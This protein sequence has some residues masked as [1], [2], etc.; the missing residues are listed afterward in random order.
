MNCYFQEAEHLDLNLCRKIQYR[1][2]WLKLREFAY[3]EPEAGHCLHRGGL[4]ECEKW[5]PYHHAVL[6]G[7]GTS[8]SRILDIR[9]L[10][11]SA[12]YDT[13]DDCTQCLKRANSWSS[14]LMTRMASI[15]KF[16]SFL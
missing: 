1:E 15:P 14:G 11:E 10:I 12:K 9:D 16:S 13:I 5:V 4:P 3:R 8:L 6:T 2:G 7:L